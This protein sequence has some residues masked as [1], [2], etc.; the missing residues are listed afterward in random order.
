MQPGR[1]CEAYL[2]CYKHKV[3]TRDQALCRLNQQTLTVDYL[4]ISVELEYNLL[5]P[6]V[7]VI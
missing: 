4:Y 3:S 2:T 6:A 5:D 7:Y 1:M